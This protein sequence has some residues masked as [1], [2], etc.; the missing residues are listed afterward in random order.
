MA[1]AW[2]VGLPVMIL[3]AGAAWADDDDEEEEHGGAA[4]AGL[5]A[6]VA[7]VTDPT[8]TS[9]CGSCHFAYQ[10]GLLP[11]RSWSALLGDLPHHFGEDATV[12]DA[13]RAKL[14]A[15]AAV[16]A[17]DVAPYRLSAALARAAEGSVPLR[18]SELPALRAE[19]REEV[20]AS[21][22]TGNPQV[23]SWA[24][25]GACHTK[26]AEGSYAESQIV[27]PGHGRVD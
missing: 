11:L 5:R 20:P 21:W 22:V 17:A 1:R 18:V 24:A 2:W 14:L 15:V 6:G 7:P 27:I 19:H 9:E 26:A 25:C 23:K 12:D 3:V 8:W 4:R 10:P 13:T 16:G